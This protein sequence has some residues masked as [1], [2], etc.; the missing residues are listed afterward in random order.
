MS[1]LQQ[2]DLSVG[3][4]LKW[5]SV[6]FLKHIPRDL[7]PMPADKV[8]FCEAVSR[9]VEG[10]WIL[11]PESVCCAGAQR[12]FG[13]LKGTDRDLA[14]DLAEKFDVSA[15]TAGTAIA[16]VPTLPE[17]FD[18]VWVGTDTAPDVYVSYA[19]P[20]T[21]MRIVRTWQRIY[22][23]SLPIKVSGIMSVCGSAVVNSYVNHTISLTF[24]CPD[25]RRYGGIQ[26]EQLVIAL[27]ADLLTKMGELTEGSDVLFS[28]G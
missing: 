18:A 3:K 10:E 5:T 14:W 2:Q 23:K 17:R 9:T 22:G 28:R 19:L 4:A 12:C 20:E 6:K 1:H 15:T 7:T 16:D 24:G 13:W 25:S 26:P 11:T 27:P 21:A 8:R